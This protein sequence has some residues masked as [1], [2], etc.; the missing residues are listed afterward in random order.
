MLF[1]CPRHGLVQPSPTKRNRLAGFTVLV[2]PLL[3]CGLTLEWNRGV[4]KRK[5]KREVRT[6]AKNETAKPQ[7]DTG[8]AQVPGNK[9][10]VQLDLEKETKN[11]IRFQEASEEDSGKR[12]S[13]GTLYV[14]KHTFGKPPYPGSILVTVEW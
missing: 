3:G 14:Q 1:R 13:I 6:M 12:Q 11:T 8:K 7:T 10:T 9:V 5:P 4:R 2:C